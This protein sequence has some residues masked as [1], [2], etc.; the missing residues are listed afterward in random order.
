MNKKY[1]LSIK[2]IIEDSIQVT[3]ACYL[4]ES[5]EKSI[6][7]HILECAKYFLNENPTQNNTPAIDF[8]LKIVGEK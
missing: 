7:I 5:L 4:A 6:K 8:C 3:P 2:S 1:G